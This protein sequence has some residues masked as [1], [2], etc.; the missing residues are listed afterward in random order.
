M[1]V[2]NAQLQINE[3][4]LHVKDCSG[5]LN[6]HDPD[7]ELRENET[8][9]CLNMFFH[10]G[11]AETMDQVSE[12]EGTEVRAEVVQLMF[13]V[14]FHAAAQEQQYVLT[15]Q[16]FYRYRN[17]AL[18]AIYTLP[19]LGNVDIEPSWA[20]S[21]ADQKVIITNGESRPFMYDG[22]HVADVP[23]L[24]SVFGSA[25][26]ARHVA[27]W[28]NMLVFVDVEEGTTGDT[29][30]VPYR[31]RVRYSNPGSIGT[32]NEERAGKVDLL[33]LPDEIRAVKTFGQY[34]LIYRSESVIWGRWVGGACELVNFNTAIAMDGP[35]GPRAVI[36]MNGMHI[37]L[38]NTGV[39]LHLG[40]GRVVLASKKIERTMLFPSSSY[41]LARKFKAS[42]AAFPLRR[43]V[44][45]VLYEESSRASRIFSMYVPRAGTQGIRWSRHDLGKPVSL[46][47][48]VTND[49]HELSNFSW[50]AVLQTW[51]TEPVSWNRLGSLEEGERFKTPSFVMVDGEYRASI[52]VMHVGPNKL[53]WYFMS[54]VYAADSKNI[55]VDAFT[56]NFEGSNV[57]VSVI[58]D[59][60]HTLRHKDIAE[61][62]EHK[63]HREKLFAHGSRNTIQ[64]KFESIPDTDSVDSVRITSYGL[65]YRQH[66]VQTAGRGI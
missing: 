29:T 23:G 12:L 42:I 22:T 47:G 36:E 21:T 7:T 37:L 18:E 50:G 10:S 38:A 51:E 63:Q 34:L 20:F 17:N 27:Y 31:Y 3:R 53:P 62:E 6:T 54:P 58:G 13:A 35:L 64:V 4:F 25:F 52:Q 2:L 44:F 11:A 55:E 40:H 19:T 57:R 45:I 15:T 26:R 9:D 5:G 61:G 14:K 65:S 46:V 24:E 48:Q 39:Y 33:D 30:A 49:V 1:P 28:Q 60:D 16:K 41:I 66:T 43:T 8:P 59:G 32:W 56:V